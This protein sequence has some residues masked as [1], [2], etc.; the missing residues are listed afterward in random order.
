MLVHL[1]RPVVDKKKH[2]RKNEDK[3]THVGLSIMN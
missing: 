2:N 3:R 1:K